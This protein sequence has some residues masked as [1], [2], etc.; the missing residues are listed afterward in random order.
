[1][2]QART[3]TERK[4]ILD[5]I[6]APLNELNGDIQELKASKLP[7][8]PKKDVEALERVVER[9]DDAGWDVTV[10]SSYRYSCGPSV[11]VRLK[12]DHPAREEATKST[13]SA[14]EEIKVAIDDIR[15]AVLYSDGY[16]AVELDQQAKEMA[17]RLRKALT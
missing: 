8:P 10:S 5:L 4:Q 6:L 15:R 16:D 13:E 9:L 14:Q 12:D 7:K 17:A 1:M 3:Q 11:N 2:A